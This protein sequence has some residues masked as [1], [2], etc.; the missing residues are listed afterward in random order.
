MVIEKL[1]ELV[2]KYAKTAIASRSAFRIGV[3]GGSLAK[4]LST[5]LPN[6]ATDFTKWQIFFCDERYVDETDPECTFSVYKKNLLPKVPLTENQLFKIDQSLP[7][8]QCAQNYEENMR[9]AFKLSGTTAVPIFDLLLLGMGP[10]GHTCSLFPGHKLV[11]ETRA[12]IAAIDDSPKPPPARVTMTF[13]L[14]NNARCCIFAMA[15]E[16]KAEMVRKILV[17]KEPLPASRVRPTCG[18][19]YWIVDNAAGAYL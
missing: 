6:I 13:P 14:I 12:L 18:D 10:D 9:K 2:E 4:Y 19:L 7:L 17:E 16:G 5:G 15:G 1:C 3:S 8:E 11:D